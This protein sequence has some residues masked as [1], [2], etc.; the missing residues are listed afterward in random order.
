MMNDI[1]TG[2][3]SKERVKRLILEPLL[4]RGTPPRG[5]T[6]EAMFADYLAALGHFPDHVLEQAARQVRL[7]HVKP[8]WPHAGDYLKVCRKIG[9][10]D[11]APASRADETLERSREAHGYVTRRMMADDAK[12]YLRAAKC[13]ALDLVRGWLFDRACTCI[14]AGD[15]PHVHDVDLNSMMETWEANWAAV[16]PREQEQE[17]IPPGGSLGEQAKI[18]IEKTEAA[19]ELDP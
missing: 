16:K 11:Q 19:R 17:I 15:Q 3:S 1:T 14:R 5:W 4:G 12:L 18:I 2:L 13:H 7:E 9:G 8:S 10:S 6:E